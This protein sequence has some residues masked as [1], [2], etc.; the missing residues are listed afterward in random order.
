M[1]TKNKITRYKSNK[2]CTKS[3]WGKL[4]TCDDKNQ[5]IT[6]DWRDISHSWMTQYC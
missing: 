3:I 6:K 4:E 5:K 2:T 1:S